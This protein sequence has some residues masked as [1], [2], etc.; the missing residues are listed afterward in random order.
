MKLSIASVL[1]LLSVVTIISTSRAKGEKD[2]DLCYVEVHTNLLG[3]TQ[4]PCTYRF[5]MSVHPDNTITSDGG[6]RECQLAGAASLG[7]GNGTV[8]SPSSIDFPFIAEVTFNLPAEHQEGRWL[9][10]RAL[11]FSDRG[12]SSPVTSSLMICNEAPRH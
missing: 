7:P 4:N 11:S 1:A 5:T 6:T 8:N 10:G 2:V 12:G 3:N 9:T